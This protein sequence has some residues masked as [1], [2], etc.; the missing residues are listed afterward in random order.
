MR[1]GKGVVHAPGILRRSVEDLVGRERV[2]ASFAKHFGISNAA[3]ELRYSDC[4]VDEEAAGGVE[5]CIARVVEPLAANDALTV[6]RRVLAQRL[7]KL[8]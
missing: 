4:P 1:I 5:E 8:D 2:V 7:A 6:G 3:A